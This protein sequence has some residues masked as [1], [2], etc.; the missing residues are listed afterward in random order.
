MPSSDLFPLWIGKRPLISNFG[1]KPSS[2]SWSINDLWKCDLR[3]T[4][5]RDECVS[6][7]VQHVQSLFK[8]DSSPEGI[9]CSSFPVAPTWVVVFASNTFSM[10]SS[11]S[12]QEMGIG[13]V[14]RCKG[15]SAHL[16]KMLIRQ[17]HSLTTLTEQWI[18][19]RYPLTSWLWRELGRIVWVSSELLHM[20]L[21]VVKRNL[22]PKEAG[23]VS[24]GSAPCFLWYASAP[25]FWQHLLGE[26]GLGDEF[27]AESVKIPMAE[28]LLGLEWGHSWLIVHMGWETGLCS[29][30]VGIPGSGHRSDLSQ[31]QFVRLFGSLSCK[32]EPYMDAPQQK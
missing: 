12:C 13:N 29:W 20:L 3:S 7:R 22:S 14:E 9:R 10:L 19:L 17:R 32:A 1:V 24:L 2:C 5:Q 8:W 26:W 4:A 23:W 27:G 21:S 28:L 11:S 25:W 6:C 31:L 18:L 30:C 16:M 15:F